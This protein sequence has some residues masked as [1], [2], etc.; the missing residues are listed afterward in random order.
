MNDGMGPGAGGQNASASPQPADENANAN[1]EAA[2]T[3]APETMQ[4]RTPFQGMTEQTT[5]ASPAAKNL[6]SLGLCTLL[7]LAALVFALC[8]KRR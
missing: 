2:E 1:E 7:L 3:V 5:N 4:R 8:Y 6:I